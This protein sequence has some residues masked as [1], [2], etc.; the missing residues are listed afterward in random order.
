MNDDPSFSNDDFRH[1]L[2]AFAAIGEQ[3]RLIREV[4]TPYARTK[5]RHLKEQGNL[6]LP[7][8]TML[9]AVTN[10][11]DEFRQIFIAAAIL[12]TAVLRDR[13]MEQALMGFINDAFKSSGAKVV[14]DPAGF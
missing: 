13:V 2:E 3:A 4:P 1:I 12:A 10:E 9:A 7:K 14:L 11:T 6:L 8:L 5:M